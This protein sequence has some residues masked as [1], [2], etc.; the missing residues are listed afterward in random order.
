MFVSKKNAEE[1]QRRLKLELS[2]EKEKNSDLRKDVESLNVDNHEQ[3]NHILSLTESLE[4]CQEEI[5]AYESGV[6]SKD[7]QTQAILYISDDLSTV[8]PITKVNA[9]T[10]T[11]M[12]EKRYL[13]WNKRED[14]FAI[15]LAAMTIALEALEQTVFSFEEALLND[16]ESDEVDVNEES[17]DA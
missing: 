7:S 8:T 12:V 16:V 2:E 5:R 17:D 15:N 14:E 6:A 10:I 1:V 4:K 13:P 3:Y 9:K 11:K